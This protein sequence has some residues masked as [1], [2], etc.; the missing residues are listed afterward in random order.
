[1]FDLP[2]DRLWLDVSARIGNEYGAVCPFRIAVHLVLYAAQDLCD[3]P[4]AQTAHPPKQLAEKLRRGMPLSDEVIRELGRGRWPLCEADFNLSNL[5]RTVPM[6]Q[7]KEGMVS[8]TLTDEKLLLR[9][10]VAVRDSTYV[11]DVAIT[12]AK[13]PQI[14]Q[15][16]GHIG[17]WSYAAGVPKG[18]KLISAVCGLYDGSIRMLPRPSIIDTDY[19]AEQFMIALEDGNRL[20]PFVAV[21]AMPGETEQELRADVEP[22]AKEAFTLQHVAAL[23]VGGAN[24]LRRLLGPHAL[25]DGAIKTYNAGFSRRD[26]P[27]NHPITIWQTIKAHERGR[28]GI[29]ERWR[30]RLMTRDAWDRSSHSQIISKR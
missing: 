25:P 7:V 1:M 29:L 13:L 17:G 22:Y 27:T 2:L 8:W 4:I 19:D 9:K 24:A 21:A 30:K 3:G 11:T 28:S 10:R 23:T 26:M 15:T 18:L 12:A 20:Q 14:R 6:T 16:V 5:P